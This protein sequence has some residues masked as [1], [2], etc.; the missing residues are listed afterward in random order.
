MIRPGAA[1]EALEVRTL[2]LRIPDS[3]KRL[4]ARGG[5]A[6]LRCNID[7]RVR[8]RLIAKGPDAKRIEIRGRIGQRAARLDAGIPAWV[9]ATLTERAAR[10]LRRADP[11]VKPKVVA[12]VAGRTLLSSPPKLVVR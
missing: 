2:K 7:C 4:I 10:R 11:G 12:R 8:L 1:S 5:R 6:K 3:R 9:V